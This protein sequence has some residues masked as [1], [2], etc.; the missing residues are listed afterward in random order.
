MRTLEGPS[1]KVDDQEK[2]DEEGSQLAAKGRKR[3]GD[4]DDDLLELGSKEKLRTRWYRIAEKGWT[5]A[6][7]ERLVPKASAAA[8][9]S[10]TASRADN[11]NWHPQI[12]LSLEEVSVVQHK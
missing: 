2:E 11:S 8:D 4:R 6:V 12:R 7:L 5:F 9:V 1:A 3:Q 10:C